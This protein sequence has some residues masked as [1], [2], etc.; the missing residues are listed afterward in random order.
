MQKYQSFTFEIA[1]YAAAFS[2]GLIL[3]LAWLGQPPLNDFEAA[4]A[5]QAMDL[6]RGESPSL[7]PQP[8]YLLPTGLLF[9]AF[10]ASNFLA[11]FLPALAGGL[12]VLL[13]FFFRK[14]LGR[15]AA[16]V[17]AFGLALDP[18]LVSQ[19][20]L[21][22]G[23]M[24]ALAFGLLALASLYSRRWTA[25]GIFGG[26]ALLSG[27]ALLHGLLTL[28]LAYVLGFALVRAGLLEPLVDQAADDPTR[29]PGVR[30]GLAWLAGTVVVAGTLFLVFPQGLG[31]MAAALPAYLSG[32]VQSS[33]VP[34][35]R[36]AAALLFYQPLVL[37]F[38]LFG[39]LR[40][41]RDDFGFY[42]LA[43]WLSIWAVVALF[44]VL[45]YPARQ[46]GDLVWVLAPLWGLAAVELAHHLAPS[47]SSQ[48]R[49]I[50]AGQAFFLLVLMSFAWINLAALGNLP[51]LPADTQ[52]RNALLLAAGAAAMAVLTTLLVA[53]GWSWSASRQGLAWGVILTLG[54]Y[55][56][57]VLWGSA[58]LRPRQAAELW[59]P[60]PGAGQSSLLVD[61]LENI[62]VWQTGQRLSMEVVVVG[63]SPSLRWALRDFAGARFVS[64]LG[65]GQLPAALITPEEEA[66]PQLAAAYRGQSFLWQETPAW[67]GALPLNWPR[68]LVAREAPYNPSRLILWARSDLFPG[69]A[70]QPLIDFQ[71]EDDTPGLEDPADD[72]GGIR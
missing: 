22:G 58:Y 34:P 57:S 45:L 60:N 35:L 37:V 62:S 36:L 68:W 9:F 52:W 31:A 46:V 70:A 67:A 24:L 23:P 56:L 39:L 20:R 4:W 72:N 65:A 33:G 17:M 64:G 42:V 30:R 32:W 59:S 43:R 28:A 2:L 16:L 5:L 10:S 29:Q 3:R 54:I 66:S 38:A 18:G 55:M 7:G 13:P 71:F 50:S 25:A 44:V 8:A 63:N 51:G 69:G 48:H 21:A 27:P 12:L 53:L 11:R 6:I 1:L 40:A 61:T 26:L 15:G 14:S 49:L 41:W 47:R 19:S